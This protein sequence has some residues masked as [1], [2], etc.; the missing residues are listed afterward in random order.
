MIPVT[1][2]QFRKFDAIIV[3]LQLREQAGLILDAARLSPSNQK[4]S[5]VCD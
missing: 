5:K 1:I 4:G 2:Q 3:D